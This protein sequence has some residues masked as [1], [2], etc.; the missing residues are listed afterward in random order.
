MNNNIN[1][2]EI[3]ARLEREYPAALCSLEYDKPHELLFSVRLAAQCTD[4]RVNKITPAL[5]ARFPTLEAFAEA[6]QTEVEEYVR[7]CGFFRSKAH[8]IIAAAR[9]LLA[10]FGGVVPDNMGDLLKLP[11]VGRK[12]ANLVLGDVYKKPGSV[13]VDTHCIRL[14]NRIGLANTKV[15]EKIEVILRAVLPPDKSNDFCHRMVLHG[16]AVCPARAPK[17]A[18]CCI[19]EYCEKHL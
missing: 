5:F 6:E 19:S 16:R 9:M 12:T 17:C 11:G 8:D 18:E 13:V 4:E 10:D 15:P 1:V 3:I 14:T 2:N 7:S